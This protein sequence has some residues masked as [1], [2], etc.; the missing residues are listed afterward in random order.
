M[1]NYFDNP[2]LVSAELRKLIPVFMDEIAEDVM[3]LE[4]AFNIADYQYCLEIS[5]K[6]K[7]TSLSFGILLLDDKTKYFRAYLHENKYDVASVEMDSIKKVIKELQ[8]EVQK[9]A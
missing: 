8:E 5:H 9:M 4:L 1:S 3:R 6:I 2:R 7:G